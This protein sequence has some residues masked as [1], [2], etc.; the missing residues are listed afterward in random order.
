MR[1]LPPSCHQVQQRN[2]TSI[3]E[4]SL[5]KE[6]GLLH[7][8]PQRTKMRKNAKPNN[9]PTKR[10]LV[11]QW[12]RSRKNLF[13]IKSLLLQR[14]QRVPLWTN[15]QWIEF[16]RLTPQV[17][18]CMGGLH[19]CSPHPTSISW[20]PGLFITRQP[21]HHQTD[22]QIMPNISFVFIVPPL[23]MSSW[24]LDSR[25]VIEAQAILSKFLP[26]IYQLEYFHEYNVQF[27]IISCDTVQKPLC[28]CKF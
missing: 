28:L 16:G 10:H 24:F 8:D 15:S 14:R 21:D 25:G 2:S 3:K 18:K 26:T 20:V 13:L 27:L 5:P 12:A 9:Q 7:H 19:Q 17:L 23:S 4:V 6:P 11:L 22:F 1:C